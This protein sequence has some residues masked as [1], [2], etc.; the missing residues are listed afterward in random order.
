[1]VVIILKEDSRKIQLRSRAGT[2]ASPDLV[3]LDDK[4][5]D[6]RDPVHLS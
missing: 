1:M 6:N 4:L 5:S 2:G 3:S